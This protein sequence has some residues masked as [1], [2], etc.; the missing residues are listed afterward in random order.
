MRFKLYFFFYLLLLLPFISFGGE[1]D[2]TIP[3]LSEHF[4]N[5]AGY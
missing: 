1:A 2:I 4:F 3:K 5:I